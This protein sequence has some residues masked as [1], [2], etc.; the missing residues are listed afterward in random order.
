MTTVYSMR[1][2]CDTFEV[3]ALP[4]GEFQSRV[5]FEN[6]D[7]GVLE[8]EPVKT[9]GAALMQMMVQ[10]LYDNEHAF[11]HKVDGTYVNNFSAVLEHVEKAVQI[12]QDLELDIE[13]RGL[14][15]E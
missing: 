11:M 12:T 2:I 3:I 7:D 4:S 9:M 8:C 6:P 5:V 14:T 10:F 1:D 13:A 15:V